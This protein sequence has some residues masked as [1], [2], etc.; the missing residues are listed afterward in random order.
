MENMQQNL[1]KH[2]NGCEDRLIK[3]ADTMTKMDEISIRHKF[4][5]DKLQASSTM[6]T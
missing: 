1:T 2:F 5:I 4:D 6:H 3:M